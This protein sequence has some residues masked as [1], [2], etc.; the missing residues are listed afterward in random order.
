VLRAAKRLAVLVSVLICTNAQAAGV[1]VLTYHDVIANPGKDQYGV[2]LKSFESQLEYLKKNNYHPISLKLFIRA[3]QGRATLPRKPVM[4]TFDDGLISYKNNIVPLLEKYRYPSV[5]SIVTGWVD[6]AEQPD[7]Y[8]GKLLTWAQLRQLQQSPLIEIV[9]HSHN[10]H[11]WI[12]SSPQDSQA[13]AGITHRY[14][15][16]THTYESEASFERRIRDDLLTTRM[17]FRKMLGHTPLALTW[18]Y[19]A[20]DAITMKIA[21]SA[22]FAYQLT[23]DEGNAGF[24]ELPDI[25]RYIVLQEHT[26]QDFQSMLSPTTGTDNGLR[27]VEFNLEV[28]AHVSPEYHKKLMTQLVRRVRSLGVDTVIVTPFT[29]DHRAAFFPNNTLPVKYDLLNGVLDRL[30]ENIAIRNVYVRIPDVGKS[31]PVTFFENLARRSHFNAIVFD[32][33][34]DRKR[35]VAIRRAV[36]RYLP[37][38]RFGSWGRA[39]NNADFSVINEKFDKRGPGEKRKILVFVDQDNYLT[40]TGLSDALRAIRKKGIR[41]YGYASLNYMA[42]P[43]APDELVEAMGA[44][45]SGNS[46]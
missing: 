14:D 15:T 3:S 40:D 45:I 38:I 5:L 11:H 41:D 44:G 16:S 10:L 37:E 12:T 8:R 6:G 43:A 32:K 21:R 46:N 20:Y 2:S 30:Q 4:L 24:E 28:F 17:R 27:F 26:L 13:P 33:V 9:S 29:A 19:G 23:L 42:G 18:P 39:D 25:R 1:T 7:E 22:G 34:P 31:P 36:S 35:I